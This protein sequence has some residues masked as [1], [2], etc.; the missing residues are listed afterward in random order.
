MGLDVS[1]TPADLNYLLAWD[2]PEP[3]SGRSF[4]PIEAIHLASDKRRLA[5]VFDTAHVATPIT[6]LLDSEDDVKRLLEREAQ[7]QWVLKWPTGCGATGHRLQE[8][9]MPIPRDWPR[10]YVLQEFI[11]LGRPEVY[12]LYCVA[13]EM[14]G[15]NARRFPPDADGSPFVAHARG[16]RYEDEGEAPSE[17]QF[18]ARRALSATNLLD[19]FG[20]VDLLKDEQ[21]RW[22]VLEVNT[23]GISSHV[24]RDIAIGNLAAEIDERIARAFHAWCLR[25]AC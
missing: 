15:W 6:H 8:T 3:P 14:F 2:G 22:L 5:T 11:R 16:A 18:Q 9:G 25:E 4:I 20:C 7:S 19:S 17:A 10:P 12:R 24:D 23:D 1:E 21:G 13:G